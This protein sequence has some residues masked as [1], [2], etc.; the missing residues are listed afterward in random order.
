MQ[1]GRVCICCAGGQTRV[2][3]RCK[4]PYAGSLTR[5]VRCA[6]SAE[7]VG[8]VRIAEGTPSP[9]RQNSSWLP[10]VVVLLCPDSSTRLARL[11]LFPA[12]SQGGH[13]RVKRVES[14]EE[15][16]SKGSNI[17]GTRSMCPLAGIIIHHMEMKGAPWSIA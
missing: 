3:L 10:G 1:L 9:R 8:V 6:P 11:P 14:R 12:K 7:H 2:I 5:G 4:C 13:C 16:G 15:K 17:S